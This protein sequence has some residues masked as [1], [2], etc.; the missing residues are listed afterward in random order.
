MYRASREIDV[1]AYDLKRL[2]FDEIIGALEEAD[3]ILSKI[4]E[5]EE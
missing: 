2:D 4:E 3:T 5:E 1:A